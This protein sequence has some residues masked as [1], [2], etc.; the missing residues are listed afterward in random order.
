M[1][2]SSKQHLLHALSPIIFRV[3]DVIAVM[4]SSSLA[5]KLRFHSFQMPDVYWSVTITAVLTL[6]ILMNYKD[7]YRSF[8]G[9][10][11]FKALSRILFGWFTTGALLLVILVFTHQSHYFSRLWLG[12]WWLLLLM[13]L[14][15]S[16]VLI[17]FLLAYLRAKGKDQRTIHIV[18]DIGSKALVEFKLNENK[19]SG[20]SIG[21]FFDVN[22]MPLD[23]LITNIEK[24]A[25][26]EVW[27][28][29][30]LAQ[31]GL[32]QEVMC[33]LDQFTKSVRFVP[34]IQDLRLLNHRVYETAG[35]SIMT[36]SASPHV[37]IDSVV[38]RLEDIVLGLCFFLLSLPVMV[39][40]A[41]S[42]KLTSPG[43]ILFKQKRHGING[44]EIKVYKFRSMK[45]HQEANGKVTQAT[46]NDDRITKVGKFIRRTSLDE[47]PQFYNVIQGRMS[48]VGPRP[49][50]LA[51]NQEY[52]QKVE[53]Y[54]AR[55]KVKPGITGWAQV[56]GF[57]GETD[58]LEKMQK[59][60]EYDLYYIDNWSVWFD[61]KIISRT[62]LT[63]FINDNAH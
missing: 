60:V 16:R 15:F 9:Q 58:T 20:Y 29:L 46:E 10:Y 54:M 12:T 2:T 55:H 30:P 49:H 57:R 25:N 7:V 52:Q 61:L 31:G 14:V 56:N 44:K 63:G 22:D 47:L 62:F 53:A 19:W 59:R 13:F 27:I 37:G 40:I 39:F 36:L 35:L 3:M 33:E 38:K 18:G 5:F 26:D 45:I 48:I 42:I 50:A 21:G 32:L 8:R 23:T 6:F 51:H 41:I 24:E 28:C 17:Y 43:P 4:F 1:N 11:G 34:N